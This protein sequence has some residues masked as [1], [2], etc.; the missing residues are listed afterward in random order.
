MNDP[1]A[2]TGLPAGEPAT[3]FNGPAFDAAL[4]SGGQPLALFRKTLRDAMGIISRRFYQG[5]PVATLVHQHAWLVDQLLTRA[6]RQFIP[7]EHADLALVAVG[8]YGRGELHPHSDI[9]VLILLRGDQHDHFKEQIERLVMFL[10][11]IGLQV[12]HSVRSLQECRQLAAGD[13]TIATTLMESRLL[14]GPPDLYEE[15]RH[16]SGPD[17][18][19][20][21]RDFF[22]AKWRE[23]I[24]RHH[25]YHDTSHN[26]E[27]NVKEGPGGLRD[28]QMIGWVAKRHFGADTLQDLVKHGFLTDA[29]YA[30][31]IHGQHFLW[32][33]RYALHLMNNRRE[34]RL[35]FD[36]QAAL[37][38]QFGYKDNHRLAVEQFMKDYYMTIMELS[39]LNEMLLQLFQE[40]ILY[41]DAPVDVQPINRRF[42]VRNDFIEVTSDRVFQRYPFAL[43]EI[44][45][46]LQQRPEVKGVRA[47]TIRLIRDHRYL[48]DDTFR[49]D[50]RCR[51][52]FLEIIRQPQGIT[53]ELRRMHHYG[54]LAAYLPAFGRIVGL[55]QY[56]LFHVYTVDEHILMVIRNLRRFSIPE[57]ANEM[58]LCNEIAARLSKPEILYLAGMFHDI[59]KGRGHDHSEAGAEEAMTFCRHHGMGDYDARLVAWLVENHLVMS[60]TAQ[61]QD[62]DDP[63]VIEKFATTVGDTEHLDYLYLLTVADIRGTNPALW[64]SWKGAL[65]MDLYHGARRALLRGLGSP[66]DVAAHIANIQE[67]ALSLLRQE[68]LDENRASDFWSGLDSDY[69]LLHTSDEIAWH[70]RVILEVREED[71]PLISV[72]EQTRRGSTE[73]FIYAKDEDHLF[74]ITTKTLDQLGLN[75]VDAR[76][77]TT[78]SG[79]TLDTYV[80]LDEQ[81]HAIK[82]KYRIEQIIT[83]LKK[84]LSTP[85]DASLRVTRRPARQLRHFDIPTE[86]TFTTDERNQHTVMEV[87][88]TDRPGLLSQVGQAMVECGVR[89][90]NA[91]IATFGARVEDV[92]FITDDHNQ[93]MTSQTQFDRLSEAIKK[94]LDTQRREQD[95]TS[96]L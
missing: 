82:D 13:I 85:Y 69:F 71:L 44:F 3:L 84:A 38:R 36:Y 66:L 72:R 93:P 94:R 61:R 53:H 50:L 52:L 16:L 8:G 11:D 32:R 22:E 15:M 60:M 54:V 70:G 21:S 18:I 56:D 31:L 5:E 7:P 49:N 57:F 55:M 91:K 59:A 14:A 83:T 17:H 10:W 51:S 12:G 42:R 87:I 6:W 79:H 43:L 37:A 88:A 92:F 47:S 58:P 9:D 89:L 76:I 24:A 33:V 4:A 20:P 81:G 48:I 65:L 45:L 2:N 41:A 68:P 29:E 27:P 63:E 78:A 77:V 90:K 95:A 62:I 73:L 39:R 1:G 34:D 30:A 26:L 80:V 28:I 67:Q 64:T 25:K 86:V 35:L 96:A 40:A 23:Q 75:I 74:A 19:W 46:I